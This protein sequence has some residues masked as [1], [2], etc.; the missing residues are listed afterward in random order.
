MDRQIFKLM[1]SK[2]NFNTQEPILYLDFDEEDMNEGM[3]ALSFVD[4]PATDIEWKIFKKL[5]SSY[6]D[7]P[8]SVKENACRAIKYKEITPKLDCGTQVGWTRANQLCNG[9]SISVDTIARMASFKRHQQHKDVPYDEGCGGIMWD[10]WGGTEGIEWAI[11]KM[12]KIN[13][14]LRMTPFEKQEFQE[15]DYEKRMVTAPVML[16]ET[17]ILRYNPDLGKYYVKFRPETIEKMMRKYFKENK[18]HK[19]NTNHDSKQKRDGIYMMESYIVGE[20]NASKIFPDLPEGSWVATFYVENDEVWDKI[21]KGEYNGFSLEGY[22]IERY[23]EDMVDNLLM[24]I[25]STLTD[26][27]D[28]DLIEE[29]IKKLLNIK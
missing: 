24:E 29:K 3:D 18:I 28:E 5:E 15:I 19:V 13:N 10:A 25:E 23:E 17:A 7:Y 8:T 12:E 6:N 21:K 4:K 9:R 27:V 16:A 20:R 1:M 11:R 14:E 26:Y 22:F 2:F